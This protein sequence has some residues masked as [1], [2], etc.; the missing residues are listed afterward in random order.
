MNRTWKLSGF[1]FYILWRDATGE[2]LPWPFFYTNR[3][4][5]EVE[6]ERLRSEA[7]ARL[8]NTLDPD[9]GH[10]MAAL[11]EPDLWI[12]VNGWDDRNPEGPQG[13]VRLFA[14]RRDDRGYLVTQ[15]TGETYYD[16][17]GF[18]IV[19]GD[20]VALA[21]AVAAALP[22]ER[23]GRLPDVMLPE[24]DGSAELDYSVGLSTVHDSFD[25]TVAE[26][27]GHFLD[28]VAA[29]TGSI[30]IVQGRSVFGPRGLT[31]HRLHWRDLV[32][33]GR[34]LIDDQHPPV[35]TSADRRRTTALINA[36]VAEVVRAIK[37]ERR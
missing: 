17:A 27:A 7:R 8:R 3:M 35:A 1:E 12:A 24:R 20:A 18:T 11:T 37:D 14:A 23:P 19:E 26:R 10:V 13:L 36:R 6:F 31:R 30:D 15:W 5:T 25:E 16:A 28:A 4:P 22:E 2:R 21:D 32:D 9:F 34:Y 33:D 29:C